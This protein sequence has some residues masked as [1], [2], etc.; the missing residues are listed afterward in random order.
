MLLVGESKTECRLMTET[1]K[2]KL[3]NF[4]ISYAESRRRLLTN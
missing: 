4:S 3:K 1:L 2:N